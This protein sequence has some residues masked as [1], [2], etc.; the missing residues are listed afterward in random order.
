MVGQLGEGWD[1]RG[2]FTSNLRGRWTIPIT[3]G[4]CQV[5]RRGHK[6]VQRKIARGEKS[7]RECAMY[8]CNCIVCATE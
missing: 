6:G 2:Q 8:I 1:K 7:K 5:S 3:T 4:G